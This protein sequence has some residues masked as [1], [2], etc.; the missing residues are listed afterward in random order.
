MPQRKRDRDGLSKRSDSPFWRASFIDAQG[1]RIRRSTGTTSRAEAEALLA[2]W[3]LEAR[4][5]KHW[6]K[7][8]KRSFHDLMLAYVE[9]HPD[10]RSA[11]RDDYSREHLYP[12]F[13]GRLLS[14]LTSQEVRNYIATRLQ[15][16]AQPGTINREIG[17]LSTALNWAHRELDWDIPNPA[18]GR[19]LKEPT[20]RDRWL[21]KTEAAALLQAAEQE[22]QAP[23][24][25]DFIRLALHTGMR[26]GELL[27]LEW[28]R[29]DLQA[30]LI[31]L[32]AQHQKNGKVGTVPLNC[33]AREALLARARFNAQHCPGSRWV[34]CST[35]RRIQSIKRSFATACRKAG[36]ENCTP[37]DLR[38]TCGSWL[39]QAGVSIQQVS[40][41]LRHS[42]IRI[43][44]QVY[45]HLA[46]ENIRE[47]VSVLDTDRSVLGPVAR[48]QRT[49]SG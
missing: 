32:G 33:N 38:R 23:H 10:K 45:A 2:K 21:T 9:A 12:F 39:V 44:A 34:F 14:E 42:D 47:A 40:A 6:H 19:R 16:G 8:P 25:L 15:E 22:P 43:T 17:L 46:P 26:T 35:G 11:E 20:G 13:E 29:V 4:E 1:Q 48:P 28:S 30:N 7:Q 37:H 36:I 18:T 41:L 5:Q 31:Y 24:L 27:G 49:K 3:K